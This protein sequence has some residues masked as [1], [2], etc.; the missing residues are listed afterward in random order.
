MSYLDSHRLV[1][2]SNRLP[3]QI[4]KQ[5]GKTTIMRGS[6]GLITA[7]EPVLRQQHGHW[8]GWPGTYESIDIEDKLANVSEQ[9]GFTMQPV[10]LTEEEFQNFYY[11]F[12]NEIIWPLFHDLQTRCNFIPVYWKAYLS[13]NE[14]FA[15]TIIEHTT[16]NDFIWIHDYHLMNTATQ[17]RKAGLSN[18]LAFFLHI[19]FPSVDIFTKLPWR[20][21]ILKDLL[22]FELIGFQTR[23]DKRN[24][25]SSVKA[26]VPEA[27]VIAKGSIAKIIYKTHEIKVGNFPISIDFKAF[28][29]AAKKSIIVDEP[30]YLNNTQI[31]AKTILGLDRLDYTK[32]IPE[33]MKGFRNALYRYPELRKK[34]SLVQLVIPSRS[35]VSEYK[36]LKAEIEQLVSEINGE[37]AE[38]EW[39]PI[40]YHY[41]SLDRNNLYA[42]YRSSEI[43]LITPLRDGMNLVSKEYCAC[44]INKDGVLILS[45][46]AGAA[47][48]LKYDALIVNPYDIEGIADTIYQAFIMEQ[49]EVERRMKNLRKKI[50]KHNIY[51]WLN[52]FID[53]SLSN[54]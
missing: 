2:V 17:L 44:N 3:I 42:F 50:R 16:E 23:K 29:E 33:K 34:I 10:H 53:A 5:N 52:S 39:I 1:I 51:R 22:Q 24:F 43:A 54:H 48:K 4:K 46:F 32:G 31:G 18:R 8:I 9:T 6:G 12:S 41:R 35:G 20:E 14:K 37:F 11:G 26:L 21:K 27:K 7:L 47:S 19:P 38:P 45:E 28:E 25:L 30:W 15:Q 49:G 36:E 40:H 13:V